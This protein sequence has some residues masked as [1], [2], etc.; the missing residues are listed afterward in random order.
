MD[1]VETED[2]ENYLALQQLQ[3]RIPDRNWYN[4]SE[5][6][7][8]D[9]Q[10]IAELNMGLAAREA[11]E[12]LC[13]F[14]GICYE[15]EKVM[16]HNIAERKTIKDSPKTICDDDVIIWPNPVGDLLT[17]ESASLIR[18]VTIYDLSGRKILSKNFDGINSVE[19]G[20]AFLGAGSY[21]VNI[22]TS[23]GVIW[24]RIISAQ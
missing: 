23:N 24:K 16:E 17:I 5:L 9:L 11:K 12:I 21:L 20:T 1:E 3:E 10:Y 7:L 6:E 14:H 2:Y 19:I 4:I 15:D 22:S 8:I 18:E 13:F